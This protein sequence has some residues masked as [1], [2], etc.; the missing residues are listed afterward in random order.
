VGGISAVSVARR[1]VLM[2]VELN[3]VEL[4]Y[5][6]VLEVLRDGA[7]VTDVAK[8]NGVSRQTVHDWLRKYAAKGLAGLAGR[9]S[10]TVVVPAPNVCRGR[11]GNCGASSCERGVGP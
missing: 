3:V 6:A 2:L 11:S 8:R 9:V 7:T 5:Q 10:E 4:R 1:P